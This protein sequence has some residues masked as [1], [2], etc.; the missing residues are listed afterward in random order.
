MTDVNDHSAEH[1]ERIEQ[2]TGLSC[3]HP[4]CL[5]HEDRDEP[6]S[7]FDP[8]EHGLVEGIDYL[9]RLIESDA[10]VGDHDPDAESARDNLYTALNKYREKV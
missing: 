2:E 3:Q 8:I 7:D 1:H 9:E 4:D 5:A 6:Y 10:S